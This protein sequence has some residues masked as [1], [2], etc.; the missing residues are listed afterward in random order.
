MIA[1]RSV[2]YI[3]YMS[4]NMNTSSE[5]KASDGVRSKSHGSMTLGLPV[6]GLEEHFR[7]RIRARVVKKAKY[8]AAGREFKT[9][10]S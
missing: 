2:Y 3:S 8:Q 9:T 1:M 4:N 6:D 5:S 10:L 7:K